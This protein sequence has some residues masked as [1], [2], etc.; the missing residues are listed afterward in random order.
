M[1]AARVGGDPAAMSAREALEI[2]TLGGARVLNRDDIG[3]I[4][5]GMA[6][7]MVAFDLGTLDF[8]GQQDR[9]RLL[10][11]ARRRRRPGRSS[12]AASWWCAKGG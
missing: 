11:S 10:S 3:A 12:T 1:L 6:A 4:R 9:S 7:D 2:A 8:A 5:P